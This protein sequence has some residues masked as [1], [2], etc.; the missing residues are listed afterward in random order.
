MESSSNRTKLVE[1]ARD[2][3][4]LHGYSGVSVDDVAARAGLTKGAVYYQFADK[5]ALFVGACEL[6]MHEIIALVTTATMGHD[7]HTV[8]EIVT[9]SDFLFDAFERADARRLL[10]LEGPAL[11]GPQRWSDLISPMRQELAVHALQHIADDGRLDQA[12]VLPLADV[13]MGAFNQAVLVASGQSATR[14]VAVSA[15]AAYRH[16][17]SGLL[18]TS[19]R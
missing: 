15:R 3:F 12:L 2:L 13:V 4:T 18:R 16:L 7:D 9:G 6:V 1:A 17:V 19:P 8:D 5:T 11:L 10:V 14:Q